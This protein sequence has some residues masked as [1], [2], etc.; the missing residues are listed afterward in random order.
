M[1]YLLREIDI[2]RVGLSLVVPAY[3]EQERLPHM[4]R[5]HIDY[6]KTQQKAGQLPDKIEILVVDDGSRDETWNIIKKWCLDFAS[7]RSIKV[8]GFR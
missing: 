4:L 2:N 7:N 5:T 8:R 1:P 3:N 6:M